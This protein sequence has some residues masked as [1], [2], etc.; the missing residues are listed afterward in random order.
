MTDHTSRP[1][2]DAL[3]AMWRERD[4][5]EEAL[6]RIV[7][8]VRTSLEPVVSKAIGGHRVWSGHFGATGISPEHLVVYFVVPTRAHVEAL[9][10]T[11]T[12]DDVCARLHAGLGQGGYPVEMLRPPYTVLTSQQACDEE[13]GGNWYHF[14]K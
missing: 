11:G 3:K 12:W 8:P 7:A 5:R 14:F 4:Q 10:A 9:R 1:T 13:A 2:D 6:T